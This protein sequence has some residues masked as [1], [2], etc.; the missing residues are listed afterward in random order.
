M[1]SNNIKKYGIA[2]LIPIIILLSMTVKP[3]ITYYQGQEIMIETRPY[4][5]RDVFRGD[6][7]V[8]N[9]KINEIDISKVPEEF[10]DERNYSELRSKKLYAVLK[11]SGNYYEVDYATFEKPK[12]KLYLNC[13]YEYSVWDNEVNPDTKLSKIK[14]I[15]V[16][17]NLDK[18]FVP[19]NTGKDLEELSRKGDLTAKVK[20]WNGYSYLVDIF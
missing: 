15:N 19:E 10:K 17:Y 18:Y 5:P 16:S 4:D 7:V 9:Y 8:L 1:K 13:R 12:D 2:V 11:K 3:L 6:H 14:A 20:V